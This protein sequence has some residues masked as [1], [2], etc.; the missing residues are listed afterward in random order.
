MYNYRRSLY[1][2]Y[3]RGQ[4]E[5]KNGDGAAMEE[6]E[7]RKDRIEKKGGK[8]VWKYERKDRKLKVES[9]S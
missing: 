4:V 7:R 8:E 6:V 3:E 9:R 2:N 5:P 1:I